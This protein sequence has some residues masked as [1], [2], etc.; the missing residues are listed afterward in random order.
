MTTHQG[1]CKTFEDDNFSEEEAI[2]YDDVKNDK[3]F[4]FCNEGYRL[5]RITKV[6]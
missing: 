5:H 2:A 4:P 6:I 3:T 1:Q